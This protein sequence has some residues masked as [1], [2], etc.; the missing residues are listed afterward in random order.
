MRRFAAPE[1]YREGSGVEN[2]H[3]GVP[4]GPIF[5]A[6]LDNFDEA[7]MVPLFLRGR[8]IGYLVDAPI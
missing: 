2:I 3:P 4:M 8:I 5:Q 1:R 7:S 6:V